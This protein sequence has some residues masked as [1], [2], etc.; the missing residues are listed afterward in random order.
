M[1][2]VHVLFLKKHLQDRD[3]FHRLVDDRVLRASAL[4]IGGSYYAL[5]VGT[6]STLSTEAATPRVGQPGTTTDDAPAAA[7]TGSV[8]QAYRMVCP[9]DEEPPCD[10]VF[11][12][13]LPVFGTVS[14]LRPR[15]FI[16]FVLIGLRRGRVREVVA[17]LAEMVPVDGVEEAAALAHGMKGLDL[18]VELVADDL[19]ALHERLLAFTDLEDVVSHDVLYT[20]EARTRGFGSVPAASD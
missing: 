9:V 16:A 10:L 19:D 18:V 6:Y 7:S 14:H 5:G 12:A 8:D 2:D 11:L 3:Q 15:A 20:S 13:P 1:S 17:R 4:T